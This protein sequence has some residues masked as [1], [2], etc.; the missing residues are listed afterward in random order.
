M[1]RDL[2][3]LLT[4][5]IPLTVIETHEERRVMQ[6][7]NRLAVKIAK[8]LFQW[9]ITEGLERVDIQLEPQRHNSQPT[10]VL[11]HIKSA[12]KDAIYVL[13]DFHPYLEDPVHVRLL[14]DVALD[15]PHTGSHII[16]MSH[17]IALPDELT[18]FSANFELAMPGKDE[19]E[20]LI[21]DTANEWTQKHP[22]G[23]VRTDRKTLDALLNN[24]SGLTLRDARRL[25]RNAVF[26]DG[27]ITQSDL[28]DVMK[29]K[30]ELLNTDGVLAFEYETADF[31]DVG[32]LSRLKTWLEQRRA[33]F[34]GKLANPGM[35]TPKGALLLGVQGCGKS[36][37]AKAVAGIWNVPLLRLDFGSLYNKYHGESER[38]LREA[39]KTAEVMAPCVLWMDEIEKGIAVGDNDGGTSRRMLGTLLTWMAEKKA[40]VFIVAT[41]NDIER[42]PPELV[43]KGRF[44]EIFFVDLPKPG[45]RKTILEVH[46]A[47]RG[48]EAG[49][50]DLDR[51]A[52]ASDGFSGAELEQAIVAGLYSAHAQGQELN[53]QHLLDEIRQTK[54][55]SV[56]MAEKIADL[57]T[58]AADRTVPSD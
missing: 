46:L 18:K 20:K 10:D 19:L 26:N 36:L 24:L 14:K 44:D 9:T 41:A 28:P 45:A 13:A 22:G 42:L 1:H 52:T 40:P 12:E 51:L 55:L 27:A 50:F 15:F 11:R 53:D 57:R 25:V 58:W 47:K 16:L 5:H 54:P 6:M 43:R 49:S 37:A 34:H 30:Y 29:A 33:V 17:E 23:K 35:D 7:L 31:G 8:P 21:H 39:L 32:G 3:L 38:N 4:S 56:V 48:I 2:E